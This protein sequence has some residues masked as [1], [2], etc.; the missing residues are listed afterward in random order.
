MS[1]NIAAFG[2]DSSKVT[3][4][5]QS[6]GGVST[7]IHILEAK[8]GSQQ[9]LFRRA[10]QQSGAIKT[11]GPNGLEIADRKWE[12]LYAKLGITAKTSAEKMAALFSMSQ[13]ELLAA[14]VDLQWFMFPPVKDGLTISDM[15]KSSDSWL[16]HFGK[17]EKHPKKVRRN[18]DEKIVVLIGDCEEEV[19]PPFSLPISMSLIHLQGFHNRLE[20][21]TCTLSLCLP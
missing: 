1:R 11:M 9:P 6:A 10:I 15:P 2:G 14:A 17:H 19:R 16:V 12:E 18:D 8:F 4:A 5:G 20:A 21:N 7:E 3:I 13:S